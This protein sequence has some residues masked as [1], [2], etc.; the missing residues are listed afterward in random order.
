MKYQEL[1]KAIKQKQIKPVYLFAGP[2]QYIGSMVEHSL[3]ENVISQGLEQLNLTVFEDKNPDISEIMA[4]CETV[5][6]MSEKRVIIIR[7][8]TGLTKM[9]DKKT[10]DTLNKYID[11][12]ADTTVLILCDSTPDK[13]KK[14]YKTLKN[15][16]TIVDFEKLG[17]ID[18]EKWIGRRLKL[19]EKRT[20][21]R[22]VQQFIQ[23]TLYLENDNKNMEMV[24][25]ELNKIIDYVGERDS[26][27]LEDVEAVMPKSVEDN[28]FKMI[29]YAMAGNKGAALK[30]LNQFYLEGEAPFGV[31]GLLLRQIRIML[32][33]KLLSEKRM[34]P[35][36]IAKQAKL[37]PFIVK[38]V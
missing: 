5:P 22:V 17:K 36:I 2:E 11:H 15:Q 32:M 25:H 21:T 31:F 16:N 34:S 18:L 27:T 14:L 13:R 26:I 19:A 35:D 20:T 4:V 29:D 6:L 33:V 9:S 37:A 10:V 38:K 7:E 3:I 30:M 1:M 8:G 23:D 28:I 12:P 24:D